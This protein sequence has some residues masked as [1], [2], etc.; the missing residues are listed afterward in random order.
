M[1]SCSLGARLVGILL[2]FQGTS[3]FETFRTSEYY[4]VGKVPP[5]P[6]EAIDAANASTFE[7]FASH[8]FK[9]EII[10]FQFEASKHNIIFVSNG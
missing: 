5:L 10:F 6:V 8:A 7:H 2:L 3:C 1:G 4:S 9:K